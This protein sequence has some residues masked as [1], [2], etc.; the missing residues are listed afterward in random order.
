M[1]DDVVEHISCTRE[2]VDED[3]MV[4]CAPMCCFAEKRL[5]FVTQQLR[6]EELRP[7]RRRQNISL[8]E[9]WRLLEQTRVTTKDIAASSRD[10]KCG[11]DSEC[12]GWEIEEGDDEDTYYMDLQSKLSQ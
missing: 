1:I 10:F 2:R 11:N 4:E 7:L 12:V 8:E 5:F 6:E 3:S 9:I